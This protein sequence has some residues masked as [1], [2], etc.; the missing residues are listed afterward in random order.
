MPLVLSIARAAPIRPPRMANQLAVSP[1]H[2]IQL[3]RSLFRLSAVDRF[4]DHADVMDTLVQQVADNGQARA[5]K[6]LSV[7]DA[8][9]VSHALI[10][11]ANKDKSVSALA[12]RGAIVEMLDQDAFPSPLPLQSIQ[13]GLRT[14]YESKINGPGYRSNLTNRVAH[15]K[16]AIPFIGPPSIVSTAVLGTLAAMGVVD[17][18]TAIV[19]GAVMVWSTLEH[20]NWNTSSKQMIDAILEG[21]FGSEHFAAF[22]DKIAW[23]NPAINLADLDPGTQDTLEAIR[24]SAGP[25]G[26]PSYSRW[27]VPNLGLDFINLASV[28]T[29][30]MYEHPDLKHLFF[31]VGSHHGALHLMHDFGWLPYFIGAENLD[32]LIQL[33]KAGKK[34]II[35]A[36]HRSYLDI[37]RDVSIFKELGPRIV[38]KEE[39]LY[40]PVLGTQPLHK[41]FHPAKWVGHSMLGNAEHIIISRP[42]KRKGKK[43]LGIS[44]RGRLAREQML[45]KSINAFEAGNIVIVYPT[46]TRD[47][48]PE[49]S[50]EDG[51]G[52]AKSGIYE[53]IAELENQYPGEVVVA[54]LGSVGMG[55]IFSNDWADSLFKRGARMNQLVPM[56]LGE[57]L[58]ASEMLTD[59]QE[60][61]SQSETKDNPYGGTRGFV[62]YLRDHIERDLVRRLFPLQTFTND[63]LGV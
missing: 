4:E 33:K 12:G 63:H 18:S 35:V 31:N 1:E 9:T 47:N 22:F 61:Y 7:S 60:N 36:N 3:Q 20:L 45:Q 6:R 44:E 58:F 14:Y 59:W 15:L 38:A 41:P 13:E 5:A 54:T 43:G 25:G 26:P 53:V 28:I 55:Q 34:I 16:T 46:G 62:E 39:L 24:L 17:P 48:T 30:G 49:R 23:Y 51:I 8:A 2:A 37:L 27:A 29:R 50:R 21:N 10:E 52:M 56:Q 19:S 32:K 57:P 11:L 42:P 40:G